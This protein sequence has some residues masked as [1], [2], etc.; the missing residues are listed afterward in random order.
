[1]VRL[2]ARR[3][4]A[5]QPVGLGGHAPRAGRLPDRADLRVR[6]PRLQQA[7]PQRG[8]ELHPEAD[9]RDRHLGRRDRAG[10]AGS[11]GR[12]DRT[13]VAGPAASRPPHHVRAAGLP[14]Q[15]RDLRRQHAPGRGARTVLS[16]AQ[17]AQRPQAE[18]AGR[19]QGSERRRR[20]R[21]CLRRG[22]RADRR[23]QRRADTAGRARAGPAAARAGRR[24]SH[25]L[26]GNPARA[27]C[28]VQPDA[29]GGA[30]RDGA[31]D[32]PRDRGTE[33]HRQWRAGGNRHH[34]R[35]AAC[36][37][38]AGRAGGAGERAG[39]GIG[40]EHPARRHRQHLA[41]LRRATAILRPARRCTPRPIASAPTCRP[42]SPCSRSPT[43]RR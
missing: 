5:L 10:D 36:R 16:G 28:G 25:H 4:A 33:R 26:G 14:R 32:F 6:R 43:S 21:R 2:R 42:G 38:R 20:I 19:H 23:R 22:V 39:A 17:E 12:A 24:K 29:A 30:R 11:A 35:A 18:P 15:P 37:R 40:V 13:Q 1:M 41:R 8:S 31:G 7:R 27:V 3:H 34:A 9:G